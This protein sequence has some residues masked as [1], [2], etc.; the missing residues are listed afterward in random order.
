M[1]NNRILNFIS[2]RHIPIIAMLLVALIWS[3]I[4]THQEVKDD[5][6]NETIELVLNRFRFQMMLHTRAK[7]EGQQIGPCKEI[8]CHEGALYALDHLYGS[9]SSITR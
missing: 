3:N 8:E 9:V 4:N 1:E 5:V 7:R 2:K 6:H